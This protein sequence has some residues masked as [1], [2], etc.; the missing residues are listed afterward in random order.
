MGGK[1]RESTLK[2]ARRDDKKEKAKTRAN[3][4]PGNAISTDSGKYGSSKFNGFKPTSS[5]LGGGS[6]GPGTT[7]TSTISGIE[8]KPMDMLDLKQ[9]SINL[10]AVTSC[11]AGVGPGSSL[12]GGKPLK[13][14]LF[15]A[16]AQKLWSDYN[17]VS[18]ES[19]TLPKPQTAKQKKIKATQA[20]KVKIG[21][22][23]LQLKPATK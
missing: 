23:K 4:M 11:A 1:W 13:P 14:S 15:P 9:L 7:T 6:G 3:L 5:S 18:E 2:Q 20:K 19:M 17:G 21:T 8:F 22:G 12:A 10:G 16:L